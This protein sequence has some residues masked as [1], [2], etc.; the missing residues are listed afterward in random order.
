[1]FKVYVFRY[2][3]GSP[4]NLENAASK[5][6]FGTTYRRKPPL[7][8]GP[9]VTDCLTSIHYI[10]K[11]ALGIEIPL[12][13][14]GDMPRYLLSFGQWEAFCIERE[15]AQVG[16]LVF[17]KNIKGQKGI[18]HVGLILGVDRIFHC[19]KENGTATIES[20]QRFFS[21]YEQRLTLLEMVCYIDSRNTRL[22][23]KHQ[24]NFIDV[25]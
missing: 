2:V 8:E 3:T 19:S 6:V 24:N 10:F 17:V 11:S 22:R 7:E 1:M 20:D 23:D 16:D 25:Y 5:L 12:T 18:A 4:Q 9:S 13:F 15:R 14:I 21:M